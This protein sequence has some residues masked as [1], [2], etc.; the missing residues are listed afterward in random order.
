[1]DILWIILAVLSFLGGQAYL[2]YCIKKLGRL[3]SRRA[4]EKPAFTYDDSYRYSENSV[5]E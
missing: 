4:S 2:F 5:I 3:R 1:M